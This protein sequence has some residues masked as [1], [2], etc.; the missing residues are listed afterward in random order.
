MTRRLSVAHLTAIDLSPPEFIEAAANAGFDGVG[1][2]LLRVT[3][4]SPGYPLMDDAPMMRATRNAMEATGLKVFDIEFVKITPDTKPYDLRALLDA[5]ADLGAGH[6]ITAAYD[7]DLSRVADTLGKL[8]DFAA[9]RGLGT[10]L[11]FFP[12]TSVPDARTALSVAKRAGP[13]VGVLPDSLHVDRSATSWADLA[14]IPSQRL[15]F[16]HICDAPVWPRYSDEDLLRTARQ[17]RLPPGDGQIDLLSYLNTLPEDLPLAAEVPM[18]ERLR[19][20]GAAQ[21]LNDVAE[22]CQRLCEKA[23]AS[24]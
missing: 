18:S 17:E 13:D 11:E 4:D 22:A 3:N 10:V 8:E 15:P 14:A 12:W 7:P 1:L 9:E 5:G 6:V 23:D 20:D 21:V 16:A 2:R 24:R 19:R